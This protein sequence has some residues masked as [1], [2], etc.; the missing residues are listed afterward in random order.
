MTGTRT[1]ARKTWTRLCA[2]GLTV[3]KVW[4]TMRARSLPAAVGNLR[5]QANRIPGTTAT[6]SFTGSAQLFQID[7]VNVNG[8]L[9]VVLGGQA[10]DYNDAT[11]DIGDNHLALGTAD[12]IDNDGVNNRTTLTFIGSYSGWITAG[13]ASTWRIVSPISNATASRDGLMSSEDKARFDGL[14]P[15]NANPLQEGTV[16]QGSSPRYSRQDHVHPP[17]GEG[18]SGLT[19]VASDATLGGTGTA[20]DPMRIIRPLTPAQVDILSGFISAGYQVAG[21]VGPQRSTEYTPTQI[22]ALSYASTQGPVHPRQSN[23]F[24]PIRLTTEEQ[25]RRNANPNQWRLVVLQSDGSLEESH[26]SGGWTNPGGGNYY[27]VPAVNIGV[28]ETYQVEEFDDLEIDGDKWDKEQVKM[29]LGISERPATITKFPTPI[30]IGT[31][32]ILS[33]A[34]TVAQPVRLTAFAEGAGVVGIEFNDDISGINGIRQYPAGYSDVNLRGR[35]V[36]SYSQSPPDSNF[37]AAN[38]FIGTDVASLQSYATDSAAVTGNPGAFQIQNPPTLTAGTVY[39]ANV[40]FTTVPTTFLSNPITY[41]PA[42]YTGL[43]TQTVRLTDGSHQVWADANKAATTLVPLADLPSYPTT[44]VTGDWPLARTSGVL[45]RSKL[46]L[47]ATFEILATNQTGPGLSLSGSVTRYSAVLIS[48]TFDLDDA[49]NS[50]GVLETEVTMSLVEGTIVGTNVAFSPATSQDEAQDNRTARVNDFARAS[51]LRFTTVSTGADRNGVLIGRQNVYSSGNV[52]WTLDFYHFRDSQNR[53]GVMMVAEQ[54]AGTTSFSIASTF[55]AEFQHSDGA[56]AGG[57]TYTRT[58]LAT[59]VQIDL[60]ATA[61]TWTAWT[62][63]FT[64][65]LTAEQAGVALYEFGLDMATNMPT[66][67]GNRVFGEYRVQ[68]TRGADTALIAEATAYLR[69][70]GP[71]D[72]RHRST[73]TCQDLGVV[74]DVVT[75]QARAGTQIPL[76]DTRPDPDIL[77]AWVQWVAGSQDNFMSV[78]RF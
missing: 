5:V 15:S 39:F 21:V 11:M 69:N 7:T 52:V 26:P 40:G 56:A 42:D 51:T 16:A 67:G 30:V 35:T 2:R 32:Y 73:V 60:P 28:G 58:P 37:V 65:T 70:F 55:S 71:L 10:S 12:N 9:N 62:N 31:R 19:A 20:A 44:K 3:P 63:I 72:H 18:A 25:A 33:Q 74:G 43:T 1:G 17:G 57:A 46:D 36:L 8:T 59:T 68:R 75:L 34:D 38:V 6:G 14:L 49:N 64:T 45:G 13:T 54:V 22:A 61:N 53:V 24:V 41:E 27:Q 66:G 47:P 76:P 48:P 23:V 78:V 4:S 29:A 50:H 77:S